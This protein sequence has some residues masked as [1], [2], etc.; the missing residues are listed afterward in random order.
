MQRCIDDDLPTFTHVCVHFLPP[1]STSYIQPL[2]AT[3]ITLLTI[4]YR[5][6]PIFRVF[7]NI[8]AEV[9][10]ICSVEILAAMRWGRSEWKLLPVDIILNCWKHCFENESSACDPVF[11]IFTS[12]RDFV[13]K[14]THSN[15][16]HYVVPGIR[17]MLAPE[18]EDDCTEII[19]PDSMTSVVANVSMKSEGV[20]L[21][22]NAG[23]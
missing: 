6:R 20:R 14:A 2:T 19:T 7:D 17:T 3:V 15:Y 8:D 23:N 9:D 16:V 18:G 4:D 11:P 1:S 22:D 5:K 21:N 13:T 12:L 10:S